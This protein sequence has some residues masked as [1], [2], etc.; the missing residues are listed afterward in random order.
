MDHVTP[1][2]L[3]WWGVENMQDFSYK[4]RK[5]LPDARKFQIGS[6]PMMP[7][8]GL[9]PVLRLLNRIPSEARMGTAMDRA[10]YLRKRLSEAAIDCYEFGPGRNSPI[11]SC[12]P[13]NVDRLQKVLT[14]NRIHCSVRSGR[15]RVSPHFYNSRAD[16]D[17]LMEQLE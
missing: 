17:K 1:R 14:K 12:A 11:V 10:D 8:I 5:M 6:P 7:Y 4:D 9:E 15:L 13:P 16:I 3:G 2:F